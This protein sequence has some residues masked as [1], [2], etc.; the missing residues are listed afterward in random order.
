MRNYFVIEKSDDGEERAYCKKCPKSYLWQPTSGTSNLKRHY[1]K[2][3]LN[4]DVERKRVKF[5]DK[6]AREKFS[7]VIIRH[8]LPFLVVE[9]EELRDFH[10]YLN[11]DYKCYTRNTAAADVV[12]TWEKEK[13]RL[14]KILSFCDILPPHTG[15]ALAGKIHECLKEWGTEKKD[16]LFV[17][18]GA[19]TKIRETVKYLKGSKSRRIAFG[20]CVEGDGEVLLSLDVQ[21]RWNS[22]YL[23][24]EK[25]LKYERA[26][27]RFKVVDKNYKHCPSTQDWKRAKLIH[28]ILMPFYSITTLMSGRSYSTSNLYFGHVWKIQC[29]LEVNR[30][31]DDNMIREMIH[32]M[33]LKYDKYWE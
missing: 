7:R 1:E 27:N 32:K 29:L 11:P 16:G 4:V 9:Y 17:I 8:N 33:R 13:L 25:V 20:E 26:L 10:S 5:D 28:E 30:N 2:C 14:S 6:I 19:L 21:H 23:M 15:D 12:K 31:H 18:S 22:T 3:S 24:L